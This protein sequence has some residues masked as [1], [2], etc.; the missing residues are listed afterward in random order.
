[1]YKHTSNDVNIP[2]TEA[3]PLV[4][5]VVDARGHVLHLLCG[6]LQHGALVLQLHRQLRD[7]RVERA[8]FTT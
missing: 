6:G 1:M 4:E 3:V 5:V 2:N 7:T 8:D